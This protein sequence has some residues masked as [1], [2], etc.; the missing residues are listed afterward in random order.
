M[1]NMIE[2]AQPARHF[3]DVDLFEVSFPALKPK[4]QSSLNVEPN[5]QIPAS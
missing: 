1:N 4:Y 2:Q 5:L 3:F